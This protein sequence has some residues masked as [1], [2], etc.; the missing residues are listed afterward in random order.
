M[1]K[2]LFVICLATVLAASCS[3]DDG[4]TVAPLPPVT[5]ETPTDTTDTSRK[6]EPETPL[7]TVPAKYQVARIDI[8]VDGGTEVTSKRK[9]DYLDCTIKIESDTAAWN[10]EGRGRIR[11]RGNSTWEWYPKKPYR[12]KLDKKASLLGL[13]EDKDWVL[14]ANYR[15]P[16][17]LMNTFVFE[18]GAGLGMPFANH[19]RYVEVTL[20]GDYKGLYQL[21]EQVEQ[22]K[23]RVN[24]DGKQGWLLSLDVDDGPS[25]SPGAT[26]NFWSEVYR[27]PVSVK[28]PEATDYATPSTLTAD[29]RVALGTL[30]HAI[31][32]HDYEAL[33]KICDVPVMIDYLLIQEFVK[34]KG[35]ALWTFGP[36]WDF[37]AGYDF[38]WAHMT[39]GHTF[40]TSYRE[41]VLGTDPARHVSDY[42]YTSSFFTDMWKSHEFVSAVKAR[43]KQIRNRVLAEFWPETRRYATAAADAMAR[44]ARRWP[45]DKQYVTE[46][47]RM[48]KWISSRTVYMDYIVDNYPT[49]H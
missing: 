23:S 14:L 20:N 33:S 35:D 10:F 38:D 49:G 22:G 39:T 30:E 25:E 16:T 4:G 13:D 5:P 32:N 42:D 3:Q 45:I 46:I 29:A 27:L 34:D 31:L 6:D 21:T 11:G 37:D 40:F 19:S 9:E 28:S 41:T 7:A 48:E 24:I 47:N 36:L 43:W 2:Q 44:N 26:D 17:H 15:D 8:A 1:R 12:I 18:M